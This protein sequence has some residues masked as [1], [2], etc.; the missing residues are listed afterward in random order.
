MLPLLKAG[1]LLYEGGRFGRQY[2][3]KFQR[4]TRSEKLEQLAREGHHLTSEDVAR[5]S[6]A[7]PLRIR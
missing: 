5:L 7:K 4:M 1:N 2:L 3:P 6:P